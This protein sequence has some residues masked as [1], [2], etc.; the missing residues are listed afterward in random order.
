MQQFPRK[1]K[2]LIKN[3]MNSIVKMME[4]KDHIYLLFNNKMKKKKKDLGY[5][6][7]KFMVIKS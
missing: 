1:M 7:L 6:E 2:L 4:Q 3:G 5:V